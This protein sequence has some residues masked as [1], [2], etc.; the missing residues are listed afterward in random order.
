MRLRI[1]V[2]A[3]FSFVPAVLCLE[4]AFSGDDPRKADQFSAIVNAKDLGELAEA[5]RTLLDGASGQSIATLKTHAQDRI[6]LPAAWEQV[7]RTFPKVAQMSK[8]GYGKAVKVDQSVVQRFIGFLEGRLKLKLPKWWE[9]RMADAYAFDRETLGLKSAW[10]YDRKTTRLTFSIQQ[11]PDHR[12]EFR[13]PSYHAPER[14]LLA[15]RGFKISSREADLVVSKGSLIC[16]IPK[17][18]LKTAEKEHSTHSMSC[19]MDKD[20]CIVGFLPEDCNPYKVFCLDRKS[21]KL[22]WSATIWNS[23]AVVP[24]RTGRGFTHLASML[25]QDKTLYVFGT[26]D[27]SMYIEAFRVEDGT[28]LFRFNTTY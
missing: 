7:R 18:L 2:T 16:I 14:R 1:Y 12:T 10:S 5:Y 28:N 25:V 23:V 17:E 26:E 8:D 24:G 19:Y 9:S 21:S 15:T 20:R 22:L 3:V 13:F 6:A 11:T 4:R 27:F